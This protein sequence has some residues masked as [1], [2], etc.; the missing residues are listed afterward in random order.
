[1]QDYLALGAEGRMNTPGTSSGNW[2]WR[3]LPGEASPAL[4]AKIR[5]YT[6]MYGRLP[7]KKAEKEAEKAE[8]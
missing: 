4:A 7:V 2:Q 1:M 5:R 6:K 8:A 3:L